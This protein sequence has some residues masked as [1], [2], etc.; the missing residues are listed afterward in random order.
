MRARKYLSL[1]VLEGLDGKPAQR[2]SGWKQL[3]GI[4]RTLA[5]EP[6][7]LLDEPASHLDTA[8][9]SRAR[10]LVREYTEKHRANGGSG[11]A[12]PGG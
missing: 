1:L 12:P 7:V 10:R 4:A 6:E 3:L 2:L 8:N 9:A 11:F 5:L